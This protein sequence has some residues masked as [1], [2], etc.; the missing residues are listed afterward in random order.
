MDGN[1][2]F[3]Q[4]LNERKNRGTAVFLEGCRQ[5]YEVSGQEVFADFIVKEIREKVD[6]E[7]TIRSDSA[8]K[9]LF[10]SIDTG[11]QLFFV[12]ERTSEEKYREAIEG[13]MGEL[14]KLK[15][16]KSGVFSQESGSPDRFQISDFYRILPFY[17][18]YE[19]RYHNKSEYN[20]I[21]AQFQ[22]IRKYCY[23]EEKGLYYQAYDEAKEQPWCNNETGL[24]QEFSMRSMGW[25]LMAL[26]DVI[27]AMSE[28]IY[29][30]YRTLGDLFKEL[31]KGILPLKETEP[32]MFGYVICKACR[33]GILNKEKYARVGI[34]LVERF[35][36]QMD[37]ASSDE[38]MGIGMMA[39]AQAQML[40]KE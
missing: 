8:E 27:G 12:Y 33:I 11:R 24:S 16:T 20:D 40:K 4:F 28:E 15:R 19:T 36:K 30:H 21:V 35:Y 32:G 5:L 39:H 14:R 9:Y 7:N 23:N 31:V 1:L 34:E 10:D 13:L 29:E 38:S 3:D 22:K 18:K 17:M 37:D 25:Y 26:I 6:K 2:F